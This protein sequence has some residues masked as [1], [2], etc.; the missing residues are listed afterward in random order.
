MIKKTFDDFYNISVLQSYYDEYEKELAQ[1][2][3]Q[4]EKD[5]ETQM[6]KVFMKRAQVKVA[7]NVLEKAT[8]RV[9]QYLQSA[10]NV[11]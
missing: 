1:T 8:T 2:M 6:D 9:Y 5:A 3:A 11:V 4:P 7:N 10:L